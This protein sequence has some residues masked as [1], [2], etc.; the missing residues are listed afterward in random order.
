MKLFDLTEKRFGNLVVVERAKN[1]QNNNRMWLCKCDCGKEKVVGGRHL[2][3]GRTKSCGCLQH[4]GKQ[5]YKHGKR[6]SRIYKTW[7]GMKYR[8]LNP[9]SP[10]FECWGGRGITICDEW[11]NDFQAFYDY[12]S[13]LPHYGEEN[14]TLDRINNDGNYEPGNVRWATA[15]EQANNRRTCIHKP[16]LNDYRKEE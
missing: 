5:N 1:D 2:T 12:V 3:S 10:H 11:K 4:N 9:N 15:K 13:K 16:E 7:C 8:C 6:Y 14:R